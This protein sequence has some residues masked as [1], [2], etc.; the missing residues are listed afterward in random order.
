MP[1]AHAHVTEIRSSRLPLWVALSLSIG[2]LSSCAAPSRQLKAS[3]VW[4]RD[5]RVYI[6][7]H[8][9]S[10]LAE[11]DRLTFLY[12]GEPVAAG[13][14][15]RVLDGEI[16]AARLT[17]GSLARIAQLERVR[18]VAEP[19]LP[20]TTPRL[21]IGYP[22][23]RR[24]NLLFTCA[25]DSL[26]PPA[27]AGYRPAPATGDET[28][29]VRDANAGTRTPWPDTLIV[30]LYDESAD[31]EIALERGEIDVAVF[32]PGEL[33]PHMRSSRM[34]QEP[35]FGVRSRGL[36][37]ATGEGRDSL[38]ARDRMATDR[39]RIADLNRRMFGGDLLSLDT[40]TAGVPGPEPDPARP[41]VRYD[42]DPS[43]PG[44]R[45]IEPFLNRG[46]PQPEGGAPLVR[47]MFLA[48]SAADPPGPGI[49][50]W[51]AIRCPV[52]S[53]PELRQT[54]RSLGLDRLA[55]MLACGAAGRRP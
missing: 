6:A 37:A 14:V 48:V 24:A 38:G 2:L 46:R 52:V 50:R 31:E 10:A 3:V 53:A 44:R 23:H 12:R 45:A 1:L 51:F 19:A 20:R 29:L 54:V 16:A 8:D 49:A 13:E 22:S 43:L 26:A 4:T 28:R 32:W 39:A 41:G 9:S 40:T 7:S 47:V 5:D 15:A 17:S 33:S 34:W 21:R 25:G 18:V 27:S 30:R 36:I 11:G 42:V 55:D 35:L